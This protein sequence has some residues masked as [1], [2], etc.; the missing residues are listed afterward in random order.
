MWTYEIVI[1]FILCGLTSA[2][3]IPASHKNQARQISE[4]RGHVYH[5]EREVPWSNPARF[6]HLNPHACLAYTDTYIVS[7]HK[8][9]IHNW[10]QQ[11]DIHNL[12]ISESFILLAFALKHIYHICMMLL[13]PDMAATAKNNAARVACCPSPSNS[14]QIAKKKKELQMLLTQNVF[15]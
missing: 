11:R 12:W 13:H 8:E 14:Q 7:W 2:R 10:S 9:I 3:L 15:R 4:P 1:E 5:L 6:C